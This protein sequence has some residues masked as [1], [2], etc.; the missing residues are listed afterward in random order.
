MREVQLRSS[1][2]FDAASEVDALNQL[3]RFYPLCVCMCVLSVSVYVC[4]HV[5]ILCV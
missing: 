3:V 5:C 4:V 2:I 1:S